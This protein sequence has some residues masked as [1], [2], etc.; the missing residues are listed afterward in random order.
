MNSKKRRRGPAV[1]RSSTD[2]RLLIRVEPTLEVAEVRL[3]IFTEIAHLM[4]F[5]LDLCLNG[6]ELDL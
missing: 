5:M 6:D 2:R 1:F 3:V 4:D